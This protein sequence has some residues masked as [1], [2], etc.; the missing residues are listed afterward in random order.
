MQEGTKQVSAERLC[1]LHYMHKR[2]TYKIVTT[3]TKSP[4]ITENNSLRV[5]YTFFSSG[6]VFY[7]QNNKLS[8]YWL[9]CCLLSVLLLAIGYLRAFLCANFGHILPFDGPRNSRT[10]SDNI[11]VQLNDEFNRNQCNVNLK[12]WCKHRDSDYF[13][14][15]LDWKNGMY[16]LLSLWNLVQSDFSI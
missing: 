15:M 1:H 12:M 7:L 4:G 14:I 6:S 3:T 5:A 10:T 11:Q 8:I 9:L 2:R 13:I 16:L